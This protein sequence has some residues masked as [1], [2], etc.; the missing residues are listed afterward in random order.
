MLGLL[1]NPIHFFVNKILYKKI[2]QKFDVVQFPLCRFGKEYVIEPLLSVLN[3]ISLSLLAL[4][5]EIP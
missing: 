4:L 3:W 1:R 5:V 2:L